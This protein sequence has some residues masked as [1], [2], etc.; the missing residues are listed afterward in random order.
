[1]SCFWW[2]LLAMLLPLL[3][4]LLLGYW[5]WHRYKSQSAELA[6]ERDK[7]HARN[8]DLEKNNA[9]L[10][11]KNDELIKDNNALHASINSLEADLAVMRGRMERLQ[12]ETE[13]SGS[14]EVAGRG[15][16]IAAIGQEEIDYAA[17]FAP[18]ELQIVE[19]VGPKV[20]GVL[21]NGGVNNWAELAEQS[22]DDIKTLLAAA[23]PAYKMMDPKSWPQQARLASEGKWDELVE[24]QRFLD[25][26]REDQGDFETPAKIETMALRRME[27]MPALASRGS[28]GFG[29]AALF[30]TD[31]LKIVEG[32]GPKLEEVLKNA[33]YADWAALAKAKPEELSQAME[34]ADPKYRIHNPKTWPR[35]A[36]LASQGKWDELIEYQKFLDTGE[37]KK[38]D[39]ETPAKVEQ[40]AAKMLGFAA[41]DPEDLK[42]VEGIGPKIEELLKDHN[43][44][45]WQELAFTTSD[46]IRDLLA[47]AGK[48][49]RLADPS[50]WPQQARLA[51]E[52]R[53]KELKDYQDFLQGGKTPE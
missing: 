28:R 6:M 9:E 32:I 20:E 18:G 16:G 49:F 14:A 34:K 7:L 3:L 19:G 35:Q 22:T 25:T 17:L 36:E 21:K 24:F 53:W 52:G 4:G 27:D 51:A 13:E 15:L 41:A 50:S 30:P 8:N 40:L 42:I 43:I 10:K 31:N 2:L 37:E 12:R 23:G 38:G 5:L 46:E 47:D 1:M 33:G 29:Y 44:K 45:N 11:Y 48:N 39:F 26:G